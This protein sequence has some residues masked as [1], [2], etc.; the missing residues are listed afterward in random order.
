M[1]SALVRFGVACSALVIPLCFLAPFPV[2]CFDSL[3]LSSSPLVHGFSPSG[4]RSGVPGFSLSASHPS[5]Q[6]CA[7]PPQASGSSF[8][9]VLRSLFPSR[10]GFVLHSVTRLLRPRVLSTTRGSA[11]L[12]H[13]PVQ[14]SPLPGPLYGARGN[15]VL[16]GRSASRGKTHRLLVSRPPSACFDFRSD[17]G[18]RSSTPARPSPHTHIAGSLFATYTS[19]AS[20]FLQTSHL[21]KCPCLVGV[22]LPSDHGGPSS[23]RLV[24]HARRT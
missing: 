2:R 8:V 21:W 22:V 12:C 3:P 5:N 1:T 19:S 6:M 9:G 10:R 24:C 16:H 11:T 23:L 17:I 14:G 15:L 13:F 7:L 18:T 4:Q 20:C